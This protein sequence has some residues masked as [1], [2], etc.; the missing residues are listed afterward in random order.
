[1]RII[2]NVMRPE[3]QWKPVKARVKALASWESGCAVPFP[4][5]DSVVRVNLSRLSHNASHTAEF[6]PHFHDPIDLLSHPLPSSVL[7]TISLLCSFESVAD[8]ATG[9]QCLWHCSW[10][11]TNSQGLPSPVEEKGR[12]G[13]SLK[14]KV[15]QPLPSQ[16]FISFLGTLHW[17]WSSFTMHRFTLGLLQ[18]TKE[19]MLLI[20]SEKKDICKCKGKSGW[21]GYTCP[22][23]V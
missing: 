13:H 17:G 18:K 11:E 1:M 20:T 4:P 10:D 23:K 5:Q 2:L 22:W 6:L 14:G 15:P 16:A 8:A 3:M 21:T 9:L 7:A 12:H 19:R